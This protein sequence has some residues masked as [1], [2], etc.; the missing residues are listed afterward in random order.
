MNVLKTLLL[1]CIIISF[2]F[3]VPGCS[4]KQIKS[5]LDDISRD[6]YE[7]N[8]RKHRVENIEDPNNEEPPSYDQYQRE[9]KKMLSDPEIS[10]YYKK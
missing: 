4:K 6:T 2:I 9:R 10:Q 1:S 3:L 8:L 5:V 7:N